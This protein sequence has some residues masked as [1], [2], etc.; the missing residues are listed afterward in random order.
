VGFVN[1]GDYYKVGDGAQRP[2]R[3]LASDAE[4]V[5]Q[6]FEAALRELTAAG[7]EVVIVLSS[8]RGT[9]FDPMGIVERDGMM[10]QVRGPFPAVPRKEIAALASPIDERL[11]RIASAV[12]ATIVDPADSLCTA[13]LCP[14]A[15]ENGRPLYKDASHLRA[16]AARERFRA[17]DPYLYLR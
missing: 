11:K 12:G 16:S 10:L 15:D 9:A 17:L 5:M 6:R 4:W 14:A 7:K 1:R 2:L 8:P 3:L 13:S